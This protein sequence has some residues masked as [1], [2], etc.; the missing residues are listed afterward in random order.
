MKEGGRKGSGGPVIAIRSEAIR[1]FP[2]G[3]ATGLKSPA[4]TTYPPLR[5]RPPTF[6]WLKAWLAAP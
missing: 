6:F 1:R 5:R 2:S 4:M 3:L